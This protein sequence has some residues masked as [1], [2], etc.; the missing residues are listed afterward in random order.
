MRKDI[1]LLTLSP[2]FLLFGCA[3]DAAP[4]QEVFP[5]P[6]DIVYDEVL[7]TSTAISL[8]WS[9]EEAQ[10]ADAWYILVELVESPDAE[11]P[12][13]SRK[14]KTY[15]PRPCNACCFTS[16][17]EFGRYYVRIKA[18]YENGSSEWTY[19]GEPSVIEAGFGRIESKDTRRVREP[20]VRL[21]YA[22]SGALTA[23]WSVT[24]FER[25]QIDREQDYKVFLYKDEQ[26]TNLEVAW[27]LN[28]ADNIFI[29]SEAGY[30]YE[31][32]YPAFKFTGLEPATP[33]WFKVECGD[34]VSEAVK[35][36]TEP[37][38]V[39]VPETPV[40]EGE[41]AFYEDFEELIWGGDANSGAACY[42]S[43]LR[44]VKDNFVKAEG[45]NPVGTE[46]N[47][48][49][50]NQNNEIRLYD[51]SFDLIRSTRLKDWGRLSVGGKNNEVVFRSGSLRVGDSSCG[52]IATPALTNLK[53]NATIELEFDA[54]NYYI[55]ESR[56]VRIEIIGNSNFNEGDFTLTAG[57]AD[58]RT[59]SDL[60]LNAG[61]KFQHYKMTIYNVSP[62]SRIA[63]TGIK[64]KLSSTSR[65][66]L[67]NV[68]VKVLKY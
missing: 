49:V 6:K 62:G 14:I 35:F 29:G 68:S 17:P 40:E 42:N 30:V 50:C 24:G 65:F 18:V 33:Y 12:A 37:S 15:E 60:S 59:V 58:R 7:S 38:M 20:Q 26:C 9:A 48:F 66:Y 51:C 44:Y 22:S 13:Y 27:E 16:L 4:E 3:K 61:Y 10:N 34:L 28:V 43:L 55:R 23:E 63:F 52:S 25:K 19:F 21:K 36:T 32:D 64:D 67:D 39:V 56:A 53:K 8:A 5:S 54:R 31:L 57:S 41:I 47:F 2:A 11:T 45:Y 46:D 1:I